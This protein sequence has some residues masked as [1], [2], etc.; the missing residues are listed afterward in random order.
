MPRISAAKWG[1]LHGFTRQYAA[2]RL[3][4][5]GAQRGPDGRYDLTAAEAL[6]EGTALP[7]AAPSLETKDGPITKA[8][9]D[10]RFVEAKAR[11][12]EIQNQVLSGELIKAADVKLAIGKMISAARQ[13]LLSIGHKLAPTLAVEDDVLVVQ[14][15]IDDAIY[16][17]LQELSAYQAAGETA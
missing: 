15:A 7:S 5:L 14:A 17:A 12:A 6:H 9:A 16:E 13:R 1:E 2:R 10:R 3:R 8:E 11:R 4:E